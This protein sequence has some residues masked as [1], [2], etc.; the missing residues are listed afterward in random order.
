M[1]HSRKACQIIL[2]IFNFL[3]HTPAAQ[4]IRELNRQNEELRRQLNIISDSSR[5][6]Q[7]GQ[8]HG[9]WSGGATAIPH[10]PD[11]G[12]STLGNGFSTAQYA[13]QYYP[14]NAALSNTNFSRGYPGQDRGI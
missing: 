4:N 12:F 8:T 13:T 7:G 10:T 14:D 6:A 9:A 11:F 3:N 5:G 2:L 1:K